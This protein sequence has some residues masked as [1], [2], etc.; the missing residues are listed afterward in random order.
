MSLFGHLLVK[1]LRVLTVLKHD[2]TISGDPSEAADHSSFQP[3]S[4]VAIQGLI[5]HAT[6]VL[7]ASIGA[8]GFNGDHEGI[9]VALKHGVKD[10]QI[11]DVADFTNAFDSG[12]SILIADARYD[13]RIS[14]HRSVIGSPYVRACVGVPIG[15]GPEGAIGQLLLISPRPATFDPGHLEKLKPI[16]TAIE[17][18]FEAS[19]L[20]NEIASLKRNIR[21]NWI[22]FNRL[23]AIF[24]Q[25]QEVAEIGVW[26]VILDTQELIWSDRVYR[27]HEHPAEVKIDIETAIEYYVCEDRER[28]SE[29]VNNAIKY[30]EKF[31]FEATIVTRSG[32][33]RR[34]RSKGERIDVAGG[35]DRLLGVFLNLGDIDS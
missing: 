16:A 27:I 35:A 25:T 31:D 19:R 23:N 9:V 11:S 34:I 8:V 32:K 3:H 2:L 4:S 12:H 22:D 21:Q 18:L 15:T 5:R 26:Q 10:I 14:Q 13:H 7:G 6:E 20:K 1:P 28:V 17:S 30:N 24:E 29:A 33:H